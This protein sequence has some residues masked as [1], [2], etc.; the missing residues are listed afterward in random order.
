MSLSLSYHVKV[1]WPGSEY[2]AQHALQSRSGY[3]NLKASL[4]LRSLLCLQDI[5]EVIDVYQDVLMYRL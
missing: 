3:I 2:L 1:T 4:S 5:N